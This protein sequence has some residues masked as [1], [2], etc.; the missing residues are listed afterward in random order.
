M[1]STS[2]TAAPTAARTAPRTLDDDR[3]T[4]RERLGAP[5]DD[6]GELAHHLV[7]RYLSRCSADAPAG[8]LLA[9]LGRLFSAVADRH[10]LAADDPALLALAE[11][12]LAEP[13]APG[14]SVPGSRA[15]TAVLREPCAV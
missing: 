3:R 4:A 14:G 9:G 15:R 11:L 12:L 5:C 2:A 1:N 10:V 7:S 6:G 13:A 8:A